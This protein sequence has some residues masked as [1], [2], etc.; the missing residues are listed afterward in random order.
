M[1]TILIVAL[2]C[3]LAFVSDRLVRVQNQLH[4]F[5]S[6]LCPSQTPALNL[7]DGSCL[8]QSGTWFGHLRTAFRNPGPAVPVLPEDW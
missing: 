4:A 8:A 1:K 6:G 3:G 2:L 7:P 5:K